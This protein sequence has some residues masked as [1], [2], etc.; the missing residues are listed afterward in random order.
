MPAIGAANSFIRKGDKDEAITQFRV[1][2]KTGRTSYC[3]HGGYCYPAHIS[4]V[5]TSSSR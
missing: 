4:S 1:N 5:T 2:T 3:S